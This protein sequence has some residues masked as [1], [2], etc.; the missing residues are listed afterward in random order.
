M[1]QRGD[2]VSLDRAIQWVREDTPLEGRHF[3]ITFDDGFA[4]CGTHA[5]RELEAFGVEAAFFIATEYVDATSKGHPEAAQHFFN[6]PKAVPFMTWDDCRRLRDA[7]MT[8]GSH[9]VSHR[10]LAEL[11]ESEA[12]SEMSHSKETLERELGV[13]C[14]HFCAPRGKPGLHYH[15]TRDPALAHELGYHSFLTTIRGLVQP[16]LTSQWKVER[17]HLMANWPLHQLAYFLGA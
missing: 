16:G 10:N 1:H 15:A 6:P 4:T 9:T 7:G 12:R 3:C 17:D 11:S 8:L 13:T 2:F 14:E 5:L